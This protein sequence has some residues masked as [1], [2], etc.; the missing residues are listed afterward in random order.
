GLGRRIR[1]EDA[2]ERLLGVFARVRARY[3]LDAFAGTKRRVAGRDETAVH[4]DE[5]RREGELQRLSQ[6]DRSLLRDLRRV[7]VLRHP[8][9]ANAFVDRPEEVRVLDRVAGASDAGFRIYDYLLRHETRLERGSEREQCRGRI[10]AGVGDEAGGP[11]AIAR[12]LGEAVD[13]LLQ[14]LRC[15]MRVAVP[16][17]VELRITEP[18]VASDVD[19]GAAVVEPS[20]RLLCGLARG[21]RREDHLGVAQVR[22]DDERIRG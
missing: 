8:I 3:V 12:Q 9:R 13:R 5:V 21:K 22:S 7:P 17:L 15:R 19:D 1:I 16:A 10:A 20:A 18:K 11:Y 2:D 6:E 4:R 14:Q